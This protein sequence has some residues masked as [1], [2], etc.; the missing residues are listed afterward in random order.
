MHLQVQLGYILN[1]NLN[2]QTVSTFVKYFSFA[3]FFTSL[4]NK[5][6]PQKCA[7]FIQNSGCFALLRSMYSDSL[8]GERVMVCFNVALLT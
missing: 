4:L 8:L 7:I 1:T 5:F 6:V 2:C 3:Q